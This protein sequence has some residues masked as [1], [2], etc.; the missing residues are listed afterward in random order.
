MEGDKPDAQREPQR[1]NRSGLGYAADSRWWPFPEVSTVVGE[2]KFLCSRRVRGGH[3]PEGSPLRASFLSAK[4]LFLQRC[5]CQAQRR[6]R[7]RQPRACTDA[8]GRQGCP[9]PRPGAGRTPSLGKSDHRPGPRGAGRAAGPGPRAARGRSRGGG[10]G[11]AA[12]TPRRPWRVQPHRTAQAAV[13]GWLMISRKNVNSGAR[14]P[15]G[16]ERRVAGRGHLCFY[17]LA[18]DVGEPFRRELPVSR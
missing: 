4:N 17:S 12:V 7:L 6:N 1:A 8:R 16:S 9:D 18:C 11:P 5:G 10:P 14:S 13:W 2:A 3:I 15:S